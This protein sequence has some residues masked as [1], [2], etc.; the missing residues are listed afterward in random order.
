M[1]P[2]TVTVAVDV[3]HW[4][5]FEGNLTPEEV[6]M[7]ELGNEASLDLLARLVR[8]ERVTEILHDQGEVPDFVDPTADADVVD[9][10][11]SD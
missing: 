8:V 3:R 2:H 7:L 5:T 1:K 11:E 6:M 4:L 10:Q 9:V